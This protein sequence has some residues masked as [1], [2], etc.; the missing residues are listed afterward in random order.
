MAF[1]VLLLFAIIAFAQA[2]E[3]EKEAQPWPPYG[4]KHTVYWTRAAGTSAT[5]S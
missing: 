3:E 5:T 1:A 2:K 4:D